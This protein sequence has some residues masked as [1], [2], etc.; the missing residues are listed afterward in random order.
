[1][2][3]ARI[4]DLGLSKS[5]G[6]SEQSFRTETGVVM[7]TPH[8]ISP[9][10]AN[11]DKSIDGRADIYSLG[12]TL[13]HLVTGE[14]PFHADT[15]PMI[16]IKHMTEQLPNPQDIRADIPDGVVVLLQNMMAKRPDDRYAH[17]GEVLDDIQVVLDG[18]T[19]T[20]VIPSEK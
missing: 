3:V 18:K 6:D 8:Y 15:S 2:G 7:G 13:Y 11:G 12:A 4:L 10:Q 20:R 9:E 1:K 16:I 5:I 19:P 17:C 14:T